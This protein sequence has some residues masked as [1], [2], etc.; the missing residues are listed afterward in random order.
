MQYC[1]L[2]ISVRTH[3]PHQMVG[4]QISIAITVTAAPLISII[5]TCSFPDRCGM[6]VK[7]VWFGAVAESS[8]V[9]HYIFFID[10][11]QLRFVREEALNAFNNFKTDLPFNFSW[12]Q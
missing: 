1:A 6:R 10:T 3:S 2:K 8:N 5:R 9:T 7:R 4:M 12:H 11:R